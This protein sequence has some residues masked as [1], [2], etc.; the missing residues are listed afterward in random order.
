[1]G[2]QFL[3]RQ[4]NSIFKIVLLD[5]LEVVNTVH[6]ALFFIFRSQKSAKIRRAGLY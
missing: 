2:K 3:G 1:M 6:H 5:R 4:D